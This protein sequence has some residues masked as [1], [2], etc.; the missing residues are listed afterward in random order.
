MPLVT[1]FG[2]DLGALFG[3]AVITETVF[4]LPGL[5][6]YAVQSVRHT[7]LYAIVDIT[8]V[9]AI[10]ITTMNLLVDIAYAWLDPRIRY[11]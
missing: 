10:A 6:A 4:N 3:G 8:I 5:G 2:M 1:M 7:D 11:T 9:V